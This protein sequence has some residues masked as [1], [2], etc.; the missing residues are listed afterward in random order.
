MAY[1]T[2]ADTIGASLATS[3]A[4]ISLSHAACYFVESRMQ[5]SCWEATKPQASCFLPY[6]GGIAGFI[7]SKYQFPTH[8][9]SVRPEGYHHG[10]HVAHS[11]GHSLVLNFFYRRSNNSAISRLS[12][13]ALGGGSQK[14][15]R[16]YGLLVPSRDS[17]L[18]GWQWEGGM[19]PGMG[20]KTE[21]NLKAKYCKRNIKDYKILY[22]W[23][24][25]TVWWNRKRWWSIARTRQ[26]ID[27]KVQVKNMA[28]VHFGVAYFEFII[29]FCY[30]L[31]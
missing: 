25:R 31:K 29:L 28:M 20:R 26:D 19:D 7:P 13:R 1:T 4:D 27:P 22:C 9:K 16:L 18:E 5:H 12:Y 30:R 10:P 21:I 2:D 6:F 8:H 17:R 14:G 3:K 23:L 15:E 24:K 11:F